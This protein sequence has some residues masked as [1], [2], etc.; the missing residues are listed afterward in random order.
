MSEMLLQSTLT[1]LYLLPA[2]P[3]EKWPEGCVKGLRGRGDITVNICW[4]KGELQEAVVWSKNR[5]NSVLLLHYGE[6]VAVVTVAAGNVYKFNASLHCVET[7]TLDK[8]AF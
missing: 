1:E 3:R 2:L 8:C 6:Q 4:G 7:W 5:N